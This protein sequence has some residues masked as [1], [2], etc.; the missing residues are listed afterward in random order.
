MK[1]RLKDTERTQLQARIDALAGSPAE[2]GTRRV[3]QPLDL[4]AIDRM[5]P[6]GGL[7]RGA[8]HEIVGC[9]S[10]AT[11]TPAVANGADGAASGFAAALLGR[12]ALAGPVAWIAIRS[13]LHAPGLLALGLDPERLYKVKWRLTQQLRA[14]M[15]D[16]VGEEE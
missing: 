3:V 13:D 10:V 16:L 4:P 5:L 7:V 11:D 14:R 6:G 8:L 12:F 9:G 2:V 15:Y 1:R